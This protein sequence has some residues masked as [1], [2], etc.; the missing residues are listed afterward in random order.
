MTR[1]AYTRLLVLA[2]I[3][4]AMA[5]PAAAGFGEA[6]GGVEFTYDDPYAA[7]VA[8]AGSFNNWDMNANPLALGDD[9]T[10][11]VVL[12]LA[13]GKY[14]YKFV[15]N[16]SEW[17]ADPA[18]PTIVG[19]YGNS[20]VTVGDDGAPVLAAAVS[21]IS[22]TALNSRVNVN[23]WYR[24]TYD[25]RSDV[26]NDPRWRLD[27][28]EHEIYISVNPTV[29]PQVTG[30]AT[31][32]FNTGEGDIKELMA[33][34]YSGHVTLKGGPFSVTGFY[35]EEVV[36]Y[37]NPLE[38]VGHTDLDGTVKEEHIAFGR[39][40]QGVTL[41]T[42]H[43][44]FDL[45]AVYA[46]S[47][48]LDIYNDPSIY[49][50]TDTDLLAG[51]LTRDVGPVTLGTTYT[52]WRDG[53][54]TKYSGS[55]VIP[56]LDEYIA[57][58]GSTSDWFALSRTEQWFGLD[59]SVPFMDER[60]G[61]RAEYSTY[62][63]AARWDMGNREKVDGDDFANGAIDVPI[64]DEEGWMGTV[65]LSG[66]P[67]PPLDLSLEA[68][69]EAIDGMETG[70]EFIAFDAPA[71]SGP[72]QRQYTDVRYDG[73]PLVLGVYGPSPERDDWAYEFDGSFSMG[74]LGLGVEYDVKDYCWTYPDSVESIEGTSWEGKAVR[75]AGVFRA[76]IMDDRLWGEV[77]VERMKYDLD[78]GL[79]AANETREIIFR[80]RTGIIE[81][82]GFI[83]DLRHIVYYEVVGD[84]GSH[85]ESFFSPYAALVYSPR[86]NIEVRLGYG[87]NP[88][89]YVDTPVEG[90]GN[91]RERWLSG[92]LWDHGGA[93]LVN[94]EEAL[95]DAKTI[96]IMA[97]IAF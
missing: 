16:G 24:A 33:D 86:K 97:V 79:F 61:V 9:G 87:V 85:D 90:R 22:N 89:S 48:D 96:G 7:S 72:M 73:S 74:I 42:A 49:D 55:N 21:S 78:D 95:E 36:Q 23:G 28:P 65:I 52:S 41:S 83:W 68:R 3:L 43:W 39:G 82:L 58:T 17:I 81:T 76:D 70:E 12:E 54:W 71:W 46:N 29:T 2:A 59:A 30:S 60:Y 14:E 8:L 67:I 18:N 69:H 64:G 26:S 32:R 80:G 27:R 53:W 51:R 11:R 37:D 19:A 57:G 88:E 66:S 47:Y 25:T 40:A 20:E 84:G 34:L 5:A 1:S 92:Y 38:T 75:L 91:G 31:M 35:N 62:D 50:N 56:E 45:N 15:V 4:A 94:A 44:G 77:E 10:W 93:S 13:P 63:Y 6:D